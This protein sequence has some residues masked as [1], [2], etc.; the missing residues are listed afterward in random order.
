LTINGDI[1]TQDMSKFRDV[2]HLEARLVA[3][4]AGAA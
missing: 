4:A 2:L 1:H 3:M